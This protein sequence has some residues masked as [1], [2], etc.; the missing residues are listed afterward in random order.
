MYIQGKATFEMRDLKIE[1]FHSDYDHLIGEVDT[2]LY[3]ELDG[4]TLTIYIDAL[5]E[6]QL[7]EADVEKIRLEVGAKIEELEQEK[8]KLEAQKLAIEK[9][10][11]EEKRKADNRVAVVSTSLTIE[12]EKSKDLDKELSEEVEKNKDLGVVVSW[13]ERTF[14][15]APE[16]LIKPK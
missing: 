7:V 10:K 16:D 1:G 6:L 13:Y 5:D 3:S 12:K 14:G 2:E 11:I 8:K 4:S 15:K 9:L